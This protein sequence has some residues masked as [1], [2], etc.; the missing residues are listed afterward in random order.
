MPTCRTS[1]SSPDPPRDGEPGERLLD[2]TADRLRAL[3]ALLR[4]R[5]VSVADFLRKSADAFGDDPYD[6]VRPSCADDD[7]KARTEKPDAQ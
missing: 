2:E 6:P 1:H 3:Q 5:T 7:A 4:V